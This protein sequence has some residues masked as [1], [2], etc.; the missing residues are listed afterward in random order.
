MPH[1]N[2]EGA[3]LAYCSSCRSKRVLNDFEKDKNGFRRKT[4]IVCKNKRKCPHSKKRN[5]CFQCDPSG[6][7]WTRVRVRINRAFNVDELDGK[8]TAELL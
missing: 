2:A 4:C 5:A 7:L 1:F 6:A 8:T 3:E